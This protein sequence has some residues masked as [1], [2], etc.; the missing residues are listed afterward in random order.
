MN[1]PDGIGSVRSGGLLGRPDGH[2][3]GQ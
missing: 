1:R 2:A 3:R